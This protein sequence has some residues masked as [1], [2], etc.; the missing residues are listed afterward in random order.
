MPTQP[1]VASA[2]ANSNKAAEGAG[3]LCFGLQHQPAVAAGHRRE[4]EGEDG[5]V[6]RALD[7][8]GRQGKQ[9][10][11][12]SRFQARASVDRCDPEGAVPFPLISSI[13]QGNHHQWSPCFRRQTTPRSVSRPETEIHALV[14]L[15]QRSS[16][17]APFGSSVVSAPALVLCTSAIFTRRVCASGRLPS[18]QQNASRHQGP[19]ETA[20]SA[21]ESALHAQK[22]LRLRLTL[23]ETVTSRSCIT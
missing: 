20:S 15:C 22:R 7:H 2:Y 17:T 19:P 18:P 6:P 21:G 14:D 9:V 23:G 10:H 13:C 11:R 12:V 3:D 8:A 16:A 4:N 5:D 1:Q